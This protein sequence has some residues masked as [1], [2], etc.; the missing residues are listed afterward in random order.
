MPSLS[1]VIV[2]AIFLLVPV[3]GMGASGVAGTASPA[4]GAPAKIDFNARIRPIFNKNCT[5]CHGGVKKAGGISFLFREEAMVPGESGKP[6]IVPGKP[7]D[8]HILER[9]TNAADP[10]PPPEHGAMLAAG[11]VALIKQ[12]IAEGAT[13]ADHWAFVAPVAPPLPPAASPAWGN[14]IID[15]FV[16]AGMQSHGLRPA[17]EAPREEW[18]RRV[19]FDLIG[20][21]PTPAEI[22][23]FLADGAPGAHERVVDRLLAAPAYGER[24][25]AVWLDLARY[26]DTMGYE[27]DPYREIWP[28]RDGVIR[29]LNANMPYDQ[30]LIEQLAGDLLPAATIDQ[31]LATAFHRNT[32]CNAE[33]GTDDEEFRVKAVVDRISTTWSALA[34]VTFQCVQCHTHP[35]DPIRH[36]E[37]YRFMAFFNNTLDADLTNDFPR[38]R[39]PANPADAGKAAALQ[40]EIDGLRKFVLTNGKE[41]ALAGP[42]WTKLLPASAKANPAAN[43]VITGPRIEIA[44]TAAQGVAYTIECPLPDAPVTAVK[45]DF[46]VQNPDKAVHSPE[47]GFILTRVK[48]FHK[49]AGGAESEIAVARVLADSADDPRDP[50]GVLRDDGDG[51]AAEPVQH[52]QRALVLIPAA[53]IPTGAGGNLRVELRHG[54]DIASKPAPVRRLELAVASDPAWSAMAVDPDWLAKSARLAAAGNE[55]RAIPGHEVPVMRERAADNPRETHRFV[56]GNWLD[57]DKEPVKPGVP[58]VFPPLPAGVPPDRLALARWMVSPRHP[59]TARVAVNRLWEQLFGIGIVETLEDFGSVGQ[60][61]SNQALLDALAL[62]YQNDLKWNTKAMLREIV[63]SATYRQSSAMTAA[64]VEKDPRNRY[65]ARGPRTRLSAEMVRDQA[66]A[67]AGLLSPKMFG[68]PV[69]PAQP[70]G[71]WNAVYDGKQ[72]KQS[73]G[74]DADRRAIYTYWRRTSPY[75]SFLTFDTPSRDICSVR[76]IATNTPLQALVALNDPVYQA[77]GKTLATKAM[78]AHPGDL[79]AAIASAFRAV[80]S[81]RP[82]PADAADLLALHADSL[83]AYQKDPALVA[84]T[85]L[86]TPEAAALATVTSVILNLDSA[87]TK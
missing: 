81:R 19:G 77:A 7:A 75:P 69:M 24:W 80:T 12:W 34:G 74:E 62:R 79:A 57:K 8:S 68:P 47:T 5:S 78:A 37:Y 21:P 61:P 32:Q 65:L 40:A 64:A 29:A 56:R 45:L 46:P 4:A 6:A 67:A 52:R 58:G 54:Q 71:V 73:A 82:T 85:G 51:F 48:I 36:E 49:A 25:A 59:L 60:A 35:Y 76:R 63:L 15:S 11:D 38:L 55:L 72:W 86:P 53:A 23:A 2:S 41:K 33:G 26:S 84:A 31:Q 70:D 16:H 10:M 9:I 14:G 27:K 30:F 44:G 28:W 13:W 42:G 66:L 20:L 17:G 39:V 87:V 22:D 3:A 18:L 50:R 43:M 1:N 83:A